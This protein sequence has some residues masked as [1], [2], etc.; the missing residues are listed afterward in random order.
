MGGFGRRVQRTDTC[1]QEGPQDDRVAQ[2][3]KFLDNAATQPRLQHQEAPCT[4]LVLILDVMHLADLTVIGS[5][6][7]NVEWN[8]LNPTVA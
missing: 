8:Y 4:N 5:C 6:I 3:T 2:A 1:S 7:W